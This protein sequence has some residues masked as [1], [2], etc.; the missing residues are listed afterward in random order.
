M[1]PLLHRKVFLAFLSKFHFAR[2]YTKRC[3]GR[4][5]LLL[6]FLG[7]KFNQWW[8]SRPGKPATS[9]TFKPADPPF[10]TGGTEANS[11]SVSNGLAIVKQYTVAASS[12]PESAS[13]PSLH[14][15][16]ERQPATAD[17][18]VGTPPVEQSHSHNS[19]YSLGGRGLVNRSSGSLSA[20]SIRSRASDR[21]SIITTSRDSLRATSR[22]HGQPSRLP[23]ADHLRSG[24]DP[25]NRHSTSMDSTQ[26]RAGDR[27]SNITTSHDSIRDTHGQPARPQTEARQ[28]GHSTD[29]SLSRERPTRPNTPLSRP[30]TLHDTPR[31]DIITTNLPPASNET[32]RVSPLVPSSLSPAYTHEP[33]STLPMNEIRGRLSLTSFIV[34]VQNPSTESLPITPLTTSPPITDDPLAIESATAHPSADS[35]VVDQHDEPVPGL[36]TSSN[37]EAL[38]Y[39]LP[40]G[41]FV[42]LINSDQIPRYTKDASM[43]VECTILSPHPHISL[44]TSRGNFLRCATFNNYVPLVSY[45]LNDMVQLVGHSLVFQRR[46]VMSKIR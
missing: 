34:D 33:L 35:P 31:P 32:G 29:P 2:D 12:V 15:R 41:R 11:Y 16:V 14:E 10:R 18:R 9:Q 1:A 7:R 5:A 21:F 8:Y 19:P 25:V 44:Q 17:T 27:L 43:Q 22:T 40:E 24:R 28:F 3:L 45:N 26:N 38:D 46:T 13:L 20:A 4:L 42:Q 37:A 6:A 36:P 39:Y 30:H 23:T